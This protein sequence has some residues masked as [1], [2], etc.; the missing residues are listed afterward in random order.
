VTIEGPPQYVEEV[1]LQPSVTRRRKRSGAAPA[2]PPK[3]LATAD[4]PADGQK[5]AAGASAKAPKAA[6]PKAPQGGAGKSPK[7]KPPKPSKEPKTSK[8]K[9]KAKPSR[10]G[11]PA[12][13]EA[14]VTRAVDRHHRGLD[15]DSGI[16]FADRS[17]ET[18]AD[19][20]EIVRETLPQERRKLVANID[21]TMLPMSATQFMAWRKANGRPRLQEAYDHLFS[22][23]ESEAKAGRRR[24]LDEEIPDFLKGGPMATRRPDNVQFRF[25]VDQGGLTDVTIKRNYESA[26]MH[27]FKTFFYLDGTVALLKLD[28]DE[29]SATSTTGRS[30]SI[31]PPARPSRFP[32][33][34]SA[35]RGHRV[36]RHATR[37]SVHHTAKAISASAA[38]PKSAISISCSGQK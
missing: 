3:E 31:V 37:R 1:K 23:A 24:L 28:G 2:K 22:Y 15:P 9:G 21:R 27:E 6:A 26:L 16:V 20:L 29:I 25:D 10:L 5:T 30:A 13:E 19:A 33:D 11:T 35:D 8:T 32:N 17:F 38:P 4:A 36:A 18:I 12:Q 34:G 7:T 14:S